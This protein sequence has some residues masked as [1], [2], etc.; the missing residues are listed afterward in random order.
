MNIYK[1]LYYFQERSEYMKIHKNL[2]IC[3]IL[4]FISILLVIIDGHLSNKFIFNYYFIL[5]YIFVL[6][7]IPLFPITFYTVYRMFNDDLDYKFKK[8]LN[9]C[10]ELG[11]GFFI[12]LLLGPFLISTYKMI[13]NK[14]KLI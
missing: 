3:S 4:I 5:I 11:G 9:K 6:V 2:I 7:W 8:Y 12:S 1:K 13:Y 10:Y 14:D